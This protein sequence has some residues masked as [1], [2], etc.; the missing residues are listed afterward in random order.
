MNIH[1]VVRG[2]LAAGIVGAAIAALSTAPS[3]SPGVAVT[4]GIELVAVSTV[5]M[6]RLRAPSPIIT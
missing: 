1:T 5:F 2:I 6:N 3:G 4:S